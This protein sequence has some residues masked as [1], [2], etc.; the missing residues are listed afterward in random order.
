MAANELAR[1]ANDLFHQQERRGIESHDVHWDGE[2]ISPGV[3]RLRND[4]THTAHEVRVTV[5]VDEEQ[6]RAESARVDAG[7]HL[8]LEFP[9]ARIQYHRERRGREEAEEQRRSN[10]FPHIP[11]ALPPDYH[12]IAEQVYWRTELGT[13][14]EHA[15]SHHLAG[16]GDFD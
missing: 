8:A 12:Y 13:P 7:D 1:E 6:M 10:Q 5:I 16:L 15:S 2:W 14:K 9:Q 11:A 4:G 3:Y